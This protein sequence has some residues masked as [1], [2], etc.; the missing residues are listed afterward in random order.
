MKNSL[1]A[2]FAASCIIAIASCTVEGGVVER[3]PADVVF[4]RPAAPGPEYVWVSGDWFWS[5]GTYRWH[6]GY[7]ANTRH[8]SAWVDGH[9]DHVGQGYRWQRGHWK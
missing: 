6:E 9:W 7:W 1:I 4:I 8:G 2:V 3:R 5:G